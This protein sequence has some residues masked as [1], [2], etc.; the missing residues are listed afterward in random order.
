MVVEKISGI[1]LIAAKTI[2]SHETLVSQQR[3]ALNTFVNTLINAF[4]VQVVKDSDR[5]E[6][7]AQE[8]IILSFDACYFVN[9]DSN[10][11]FLEVSYYNLMLKKFINIIIIP[12]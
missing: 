6:I 5:E 7:E 2:Q 12:V 3:E 11:E 1:A 4:K 8:N 9:V 10:H